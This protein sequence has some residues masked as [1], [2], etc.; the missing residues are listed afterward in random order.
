MFY[1]FRC[2]CGP[3][4]YAK[5]YLSEIKSAVHQQKHTTKFHQDIHLIIKNKTYAL[6]DAV[7]FRHVCLA[8]VGMFYL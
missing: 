1:Y 5:Q 7:I 6:T 3:A 2:K 8:A 4:L